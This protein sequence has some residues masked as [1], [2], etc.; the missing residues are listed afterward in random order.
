MLSCL[1]FDQIS[2]HIHRSLRINDIKKLSDNLFAELFN[3]FRTYFYPVQG[4]NIK[5][6]VSKVTTAITLKIVEEYMIYLLS[7]NHFS[8]LHQRSVLDR[9]LSHYIYL[10]FRFVFL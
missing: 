6:R 1:I 2:I 7:L 9:S 3:L 5:N 10:I 4:S 8:K